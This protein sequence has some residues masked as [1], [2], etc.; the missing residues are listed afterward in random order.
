MQTIPKPPKLTK[1]GGKGPLASKN[2]SIL[3]AV[4]T[5]AVAGVLI[6][7]FLQQYRDGVNNEGV[8]TPVLVAEQ[9][10]EQGASG[11]TVGAQGL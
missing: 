9:I 4:I 7:L 1:D 6:V 10:I 3:A 2:G 11:D 5:A 8:P